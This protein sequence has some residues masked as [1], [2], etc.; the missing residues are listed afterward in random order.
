MHLDP[1]GRAFIARTPTRRTIEAATCKRAAAV[2]LNGF[3]GV[4]AD[5][6]TTCMFLGLR[7]SKY[8]NNTYP[9][10]PKLYM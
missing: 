6:H 9:L 7:R 4:S 5:T 8:V 1:I 2:V 3:S 10:A